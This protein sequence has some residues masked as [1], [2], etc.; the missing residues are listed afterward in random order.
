MPTR[1]PNERLWIALCVCALLALTV[2]P[3]VV[4]WL[5]AP[6][7]RVFTGV[8]YNPWD[9]HSYLAKMRQGWDGAWLFH[10]PFT[11]EPHDG[12]FIF[13]FYLLLGHVARVLGLSLPLTFHLAR[14]LASAFMFAM[15]WR[16]MGRFFG[17]AAR[18]RA[19]LLTALGA[20]FGWLFP[21]AEPLLPDLWIPEAFAFYSALSNP[22]F[23]LAVGLMAAL[24]DMSLA[25]G[26]P[27]RLAW[28]AACGLAMAVVQPLA[29]PVILA[30]LG[31]YALARAV[32]RREWRGPLR[33]AVAAGVAGAPVLGYDVW[34]YGA[35]GALAAWSAQ[36]VTA[37]P[38]AWHWLAG[39]GLM[40]ALA[41]VGVWAAWRQ[42][43]SP[44]DLAVVWVGVAAVG[45]YVP[46]AL[47]RR[48]SI[49]LEVPVGILAAAGFGVLTARAKPRLGNLAFAVVQAAVSLS[50]AMLLV[51]GI[52][53]AVGGEARV[54]VSGDEA[55]AL[56][57]L[58]DASGGRGVVAASPTLSTI[59]PGWAGN[60]VVYGHPYETIRAEEKKAALERFFAQ[61]DDE[62]RRRFL[63]EHGVAFVIWGPREKAMAASFSPQALG[64]RLLARCGNVEVWATGER[65]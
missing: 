61:G 53:G 38:P 18:R 5:G 40:A 44:L 35:N 50:S 21:T 56:T 25:D 54:F 12:A 48:F 34:V 28:A 59:V 60:P 32:Q 42:R 2:A 30:V 11:E 63:A 23:P 65:P 7:G 31:A 57:A 29:L 17:G 4:A 14:L 33:V 6:E 62:E 58:R 37:S 49:G 1:E 15:L 13:T 8:L 9:G 16:V 22:H 3:Y 43:P 41:A 26:R 19:F 45:L 24:A 51:L 64:L 52:V 46:F 47:Q 55:C 39:Y 36:N 27:G 20:G 10:L